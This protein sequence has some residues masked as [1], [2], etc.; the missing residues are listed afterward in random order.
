MYFLWYSAR[1]IPFHYID[2]KN[3]LK[4]TRSEKKL[5]LGFLKSAFNAD[6]DKSGAGWVDENAPEIGALGRLGIGEMG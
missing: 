4:I 5:K 2:K 3:R 1:K 6:D